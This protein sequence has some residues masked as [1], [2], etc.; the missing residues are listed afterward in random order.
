LNFLVFVFSDSGFS[1]FLSVAEFHKNTCILIRFY[2]DCRPWAAD[3]A[4]WDYGENDLLPSDLDRISPQLSQA[5]ARYPDLNNVGIKNVIN[6][7]FTFAPDGNP[8]VGPVEGTGW[9][10]GLLLLLFFFVGTFLFF[11]FFFW[12]HLNSSEGVFFSPQFVS[13]FPISG[14][15][16]DPKIRNYWVA[17]AVMAGFSQGGGVGLTL[18]E[19]MVHG[20][21]TSYPDMFA[22]DVARYGPWAT[23]AYALQKSQVSL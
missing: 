21:A 3:R 2:Q 11:I 13:F 19:W 22:M 9:S 1:L 12:V 6:G 10:F 14:L 8:L 4:P 20:Q 23:K 17:C 16:R 7:P 18:A 5:Y 15:A